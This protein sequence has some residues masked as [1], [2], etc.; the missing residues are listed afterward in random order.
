MRAIFGHDGGVQGM[1][2]SYG[3]SVSGPSAF[4]QAQSQ[5]TAGMTGLAPAV[6]RPHLRGSLVPARSGQ[7]QRV[8]EDWSATGEPTPARGPDASTEV[9]LT[10]P[11]SP[12]AGVPLSDVMAELHR[13]FVLNVQETEHLERAITHGLLPT[14]WQRVD[15][16]EALRFPRRS[17][18]A[19]PEAKPPALPTS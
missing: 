13:Q 6:R 10:D 16:C 11:A 15:A 8:H 1:T 17:R 12:A 3:T 18:E 5:Y 2:T 14:I 19:S 7:P 4:A 9:N